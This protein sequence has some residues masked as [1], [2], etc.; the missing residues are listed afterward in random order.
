MIAKVFFDTNVIID[1][2]TG[3]DSNYRDSQ[4]LMV[5]AA[6]KEIKGYISSK[7]ITDIYYILRKYTKDEAK[8]RAFIKLVSESFEI[9]P[10]FPAD[11]SYSLNSKIDD[12]EDAILD[13]AAKVNC[14]PFFVTNDSEHFKNANSV[15]MNPHDF[16]TFI[17]NGNLA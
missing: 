12:Y 7:Q 14:I 4:T 8:K 9:L 17:E 11:V 13:E 6:K 15:V 5:K 10:L 3:R 2:I 1:A 16:L